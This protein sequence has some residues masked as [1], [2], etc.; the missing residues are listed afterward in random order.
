M[1][2]NEALDDYEQAAQAYVDARNLYRNEK[3]KLVLLILNPPEEQRPL[4][5]KKPTEKQL[6]AMVDS[7]L[8]LQLLR[9]DR[10][11]KE[12]LAISCRMAAE[13]VLKD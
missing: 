8:K 13:A 11:Q 4:G 1:T 3:A 5:W 2:I 12:I 7:N 6:D 10:D 9:A